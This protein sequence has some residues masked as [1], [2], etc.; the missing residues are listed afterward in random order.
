MKTIK[1]KCE[2]CGIPF[3]KL[4]KEFKRCEKKEMKHFCNQS[5]S[6]SHRNK[7]MSEE[8]W[9]TIP[10]NT[11]IKKYSGNRLTEYTPFKI[12]LRKGRASIIKHKNDID[13]DEKYLKELWNKQNGICPYTGIKMELMKTSSQNHKLKSLKKASLD[14]IDSSKGYI[15]GNVEFVCMAINNAKSNFKK[16]EMK[17]FIKEIISSHKNTISI[18]QEQPP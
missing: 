11:N 10:S 8:F 6:T 18:T 9:K 2:N 3:E 5:C 16:E 12:Y 15:R 4:L 17:S 14:R 13:I 1:I 7:N